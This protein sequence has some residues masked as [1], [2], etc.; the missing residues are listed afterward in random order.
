MSKCGK[1]CPTCGH[2]LGCNPHYPTV[3]PDINGML[4]LAAKDCEGCKYCDSR[5]DAYVDSL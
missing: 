3:D 1:W 2:C 4:A 5:F